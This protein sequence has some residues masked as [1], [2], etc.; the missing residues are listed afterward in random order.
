[1][2]SLGDRVDFQQEKANEFLQVSQGHFRPTSMHPSWMGKIKCSYCKTT[3]WVNKAPSSGP[4]VTYSWIKRHGNN[5]KKKPIG[6]ITLNTGSYTN[7][8]FGYSGG[9]GG[10]S[11]ST[12]VASAGGGGNGAGGTYTITTASAGL[13]PA[14]STV[15]TRKLRAGSFVYGTSNNKGAFVVTP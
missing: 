6:Y 5:C 4:G 14:F 3:G 8:N 9:S 12:G 2:D 1:M 11:G 10:V 7:S 15:Y 13:H